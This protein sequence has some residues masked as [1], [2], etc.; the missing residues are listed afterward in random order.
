M[1]V[2]KCDSGSN[3]KES[4]IRDLRPE[5][6]DISPASSPGAAPSIED[7]SHAGFPDTATS[8]LLPVWPSSP[9]FTP[10]DGLSFRWGELS[11]SEHLEAI[12]IG[13]P[14]RGQFP[15][16]PVVAY[17]QTVLNAQEA[18]GKGI[19][20]LVFY[21]FLNGKSRVD[22]E[23]VFN[24]NVQDLT[25]FLD[26]LKGVKVVVEMVPARWDG[27]SFPFGEARNI[28]FKRL[29]QADV[30]SYCMTDGDIEV[31]RGAFEILLK[32]MALSESM[33]G[34]TGYRF[35]DNVLTQHQ[36][37]L[38]ADFSLRS[39]LVILGLDG[40]SRRDDYFGHPNETFM[41]FINSAC[42]MAELEH[43]F[44]TTVNEGIYA[45]ENARKFGI[46]VEPP[47]RERDTRVI[48]HNA[49]RFL[50]T[51]GHTVVAGGRYS[52]KELHE[53]Y[54]KPVSLMPQSV[55]R[56]FNF[57]SVLSRYFH[58]GRGT[59]YP[60]LHWFTLSR[61]CLK[62]GL[63]PA[64]ARL[65]MAYAK[66]HIQ[67]S[68]LNQSL[69]SF[70][71]I[72]VLRVPFQE[73]LTKTLDADIACF[74]AK[75]QRYYPDRD[76]IRLLE[77]MYSWGK[78][79]VTCVQ[80]E[81]D[82]KGAGVTSPALHQSDIDLFLSR[83]PIA[84]AAAERAAEQNSSYDDEDE[85]SQGG[86]DL[87][88]FE[89]PAESPGRLS[90]SQ[91]GTDHPLGSSAWTYEKKVTYKSELETLRQ[92]YRLNKPLKNLATLIMPTHFG[93]SHIIFTDLSQKLAIIDYC[94]H[95]FGELT[96]DT[97]SNTIQCLLHPL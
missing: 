50:T 48:L 56:P 35:S 16:Q 49:A 21:V 12:H 8:S 90:P 68:L 41:F 53:A 54:L 64:E 33:V 97:L 43:P 86:N 11:K 58:M 91:T 76:L 29:L 60:L 79:A 88:L 93:T 24:K 40:S 13:L 59:F 45:A 14:S 23:Q 78:G 18:A 80:D 84:K 77:A 27:E 26:Q 38:E 85:D 25:A 44:G 36:E 71:L 89:I 52:P 62:L 95:W 31:S 42:K 32:K 30:P 3:S 87:D 72:S 83:T 55:W 69:P 2:T 94:L 39:H 37:M 92:I 10:L 4:R 67:A 20:P 19:R 7:I 63:G 73:L 5:I 1:C 66:D 65:L 61:Y 96:E 82:R 81:L 22:T 9:S 28:L 15:D 51:D 17:L 46:V 74:K 57:T 6:E 34:H 47:P 75:M 70:P